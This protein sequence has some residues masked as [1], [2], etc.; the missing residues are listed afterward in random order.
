MSFVLC[1]F[2]DQNTSETRTGMSQWNPSG[3]FIHKRLD[4]AM[5]VNSHRYDM[6]IIV[7]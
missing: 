2:W 1:A 4:A 6:V 7:K 3:K 5:S